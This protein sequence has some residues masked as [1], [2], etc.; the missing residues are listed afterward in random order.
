MY[1]RTL[2]AIVVQMELV[3]FENSSYSKI[4]KKTVENVKTWYIFDSRN[5]YGYLHFLQE[6]L[7]NETLVR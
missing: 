7:R 5:L 2:A 1:I 3:Y 6:Q 4:E